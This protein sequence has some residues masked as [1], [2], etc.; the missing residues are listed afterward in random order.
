MERNVND[1]ERGISIAAGALLLIAGLK[2]SGRMR[3]SLLSSGA[4]LAFR[5]L[6]G[7]CPV[8]QLLGRE[9]DEVRAW[10]AHLVPANIS[11]AL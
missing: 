7:Y 4:G 5:G 11:A 6:S 3:S 8:N 10:K 9:T 2:A 1:W